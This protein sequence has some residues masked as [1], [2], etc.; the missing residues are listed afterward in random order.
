VSASEDEDLFRLTWGQFVLGYFGIMIGL[1][2]LAAL[3]ARIWQVDGDRSIICL[4]GAMF[5]LASTGRPR[6]LY[7]IIRNTGWFALIWNRKAM[8]G[9]LAFLGLVLL[10]VGLLASTSSLH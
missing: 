5:L 4:G 7:T 1:V 6:Y 2:G 3:L 9:L 10:G 8:R